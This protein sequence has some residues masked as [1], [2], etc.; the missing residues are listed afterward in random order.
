MNLDKNSGKYICDSCKTECT[1]P[2]EKAIYGPF[3][4]TYITE[5]YISTM[6][7]CGLCRQYVFDENNP[8]YF[9]NKENLSPIDPPKT[10]LPKIDPPTTD[11]PKTDLPK[12][13]DNI[14]KDLETEP[15][16]DSSGYLFNDFIS[17]YK[18]DPEE[19][20]SWAHDSVKNM[21]ELGYLKGHP[22]YEKGGYDLLPHDDFVT[23]QL[24]ALMARILED[25]GYIVDTSENNVYD[26]D[27][28]SK[29]ADWAVDDYKYIMEMYGKIYK[30]K[31]GE[32]LV[33]QIFPN[34]PNWYSK[35]LTRG[36]AA[37][38]IGTLF[39][40]F[41]K[42]QTNFADWNKVPENLKGGISKA[43]DLEIMAGTKDNKTGIFSIK[44]DDK[45]KR[46]QGV[47]LLERL[48]NVLENSK[49]SNLI[50]QIK[51]M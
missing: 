37:A 13:E 20:N 43:I 26:L 19:I 34:Q 23:V 33:K 9:K 27:E 49:G 8:K 44:P 45:L 31:T 24:F 6:W 15:N 10:N 7:E 40:E 21:K 46:L 12:G 48:Y 16:T 32:A 17:K 5:D 2:I 38:L 35:P 29:V 30:D 3:K 47:V 51:Q 22:N 36:E 1:H 11:L 4:N 39:G 41:N 28:V 50:T 14:S 25:Q 18:D 42:E